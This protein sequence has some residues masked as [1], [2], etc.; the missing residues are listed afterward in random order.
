[1]AISVFEAAKALGDYS[2][3]KI[4]NLKMQKMLYFAHMFFLGRTGQPLIKEEFEA[5][6]YGPVIPALYSKTSFFGSENIGDIFSDIKLDPLSNTK[7]YEVLKETAET[8]LSR[9]TSQ[10]VNI[11]HHEKG[12]WAKNYKPNIKGLKIPNKDI[13]L[14]YQTLYADMQNSESN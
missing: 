10:L 8:L 13:L 4:T 2:Q 5:W 6:D 11:T 1:M 12:A 3:W 9:P 7:E 14:E